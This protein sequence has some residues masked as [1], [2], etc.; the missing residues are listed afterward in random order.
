[1]TLFVKSAGDRAPV[2]DATNSEMVNEVIP[3]D[4][5]KVS[6]PVAL[7]PV[8]GANRNPLSRRLSAI[9]KQ[10]AIVHWEV[11]CNSDGKSDATLQLM[12]T[13]IQCQAGLD[14]RDIVLETRDILSDI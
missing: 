1:M 2:V 5:K 10:Y 11:G 9:G 7:T 6:C 13:D 8:G 4:S 14:M 12:S 3:I